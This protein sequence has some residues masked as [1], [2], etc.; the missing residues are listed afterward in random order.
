[1]GVSS[2]Y[3]RRPPAPHPPPP[4]PPPPPPPDPAPAAAMTA[5][6]SRLTAAVAAVRDPY[7]LHAVLPLQVDEP[8]RIALPRRVCAAAIAYVLGRG[9]AVDGVRGQAIPIVGRLEGRF[10][11][12]DVLHVHCDVRQAGQLKEKQREHLCGVHTA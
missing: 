11:A 4:L 9:V 7:F 10:A 3:K 5:T 12:G 2:P 8:P 6:T 1:M